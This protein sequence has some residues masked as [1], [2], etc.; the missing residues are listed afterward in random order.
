MNEMRYI[1]KKS[2]G[3]Y[4][5]YVID[6]QTQSTVRRFHI[7]KNPGWTGATEMAARLNREAP[8]VEE[9]KASDDRFLHTA[10]KTNLV[11]DI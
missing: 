3:S 4:W 10:L 11:F 7:L 9:K 1:V 8:H 2:S 5:I 6:S